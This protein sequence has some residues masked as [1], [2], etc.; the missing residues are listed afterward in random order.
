MKGNNYIQ[1]Q[2]LQI[3]KIYLTQYIPHSQRS[4]LLTIRLNKILPEILESS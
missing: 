2:I 1:S 4:I 3:D